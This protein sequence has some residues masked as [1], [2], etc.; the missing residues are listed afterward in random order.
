MPHVTFNTPDLYQ[1]VTRPMIVN[2]VRQIIIATGMPPDTFI[3]YTGEQNGTP[4]HNSF[5]DS[6]NFVKDQYDNYLNTFSSKFPFSGKIV[7]KSNETIEEETLLNTPVYYQ[8]QFHIFKNEKLGIYLYPNYEKVNVELN[9][10]Y[11]TRD[12]NEAVQWRN[13]IRR[14]IRLKYTDESFASNYKYPVSI[15]H[16]AFLKMLWELQERVEPYNETF[17]EFLKKGL[18]SNYTVLTGV[19]GS[20]GE[21]LLGINQT[22]LDILGNFDFPEIPKEERGDNGTNYLINFTYRFKYERP[23]A[24]S[25]TYPLVV[26][27]QLIPARYRPDHQPYNPSVINDGIGSKTTTLFNRLLS[28]SYGTAFELDKHFY[29]NPWYDDFDPNMR[30]ESQSPVLQMMICIEP[31]D[32]TLVVK[33]D[34]IES[35]GGY[36]FTDEML[37]YLKVEHNWLTTNRGSGILMTL[38]RD[39]AMLHEDL[40]YVTENLEVRT[41]DPMALRER[42]HLI[43]TVCNNLPMLSKRAIDLLRNNP[44][45]FNLILNILDPKLLEGPYRPVPLKGVYITQKEWKRVCDYI[46]T[47]NEH[48]RRNRVV[49][50]PTI[51]NSVLIN[52]NKDN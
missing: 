24:C 12:K 5:M 50:R 3:E 1:A 36:Q 52:T 16:I 38:Y 4:T 25:L 26:H 27:N 46:V 43:I 51:L 23:Y 31:D 40:L 15:T 34:D 17:T 6:K 30:P 21:A 44:N 9:F 7:V 33:L 41:K 10:E 13:D 35:M 42:Y 48:Y 39:D 37:E 32:P 49:F 29:R 22:Q 8:D 18:V 45:Y 14:R 47:T 11:R 2:I 20:K 28:R 19:S